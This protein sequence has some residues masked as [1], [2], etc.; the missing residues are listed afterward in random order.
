MANY[1]IYRYELRFCFNNRDQVKEGE[2]EIGIVIQTKPV[3]N[4]DDINY[5]LYAR[6]QL[7]T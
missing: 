6:L 5:I 1:E 3:I 2:I 7:V 4:R